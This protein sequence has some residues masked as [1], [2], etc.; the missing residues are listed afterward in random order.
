MHLVV[1]G[2][3]HAVLHLFWDSDRLLLGT[4]SPASSSSSSAS[5]SASPTAAGTPAR[6]RRTGQQLYRSLALRLPLLAISA[7]TRALASLFI[8]VPVYVL[9]LRAPSW[10]LTL[11]LFRPFY[12][13]P[14]SSLPPMATPFASTLDFV[15]RCMLAGFLFSVLLLVSNAAFSLFL[16]NEP[17]KDG[18]PLTSESKDPNGSLLN[19]LRSKKPNVKAFALWELAFIARDFS[20]RRVA[21]Y[22]DI[23]RKDGPAWSQ[24]CKVCLDV[25]A[26][27]EA[28]VDPQV[29]VVASAAAATGSE[30]DASLRRLTKSVRDHAGIMVAMPARKNT[31]QSEVEKMVTKVAIDPQASP[32]LSPM[33]HKALGGARRRLQEVQRDISGPENAGSS[34]QQLARHVLA[35]P[36]VGWP[37]RLTF[38][39]RITAAVL[40]GP[41]GEPSIY[42]NAISALRLLAVHSLQED[43]FG[44][45]QRDVAAIVRALT[46]ATAKLDAF[47]AAFPVH[48]TDVL[49]ERDCPEV[50]DIRA[51][52]KDGLADLLASFGQYSRDLRLTKTDVRLAEEAAS[53][54]RIQTDAPMSEEMQQ[55]R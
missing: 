40:G 23:E 7:F 50:D 52:L 30:E 3:L 48:W 26:T 16:V 9:F 25:V 36:V 29:V 45:V 35:L 34:V 31:F 18:R 54:G 32:R 11:A 53:S 14:K 5:P 15:P 2:T 24:I 44:N 12:S 39:N 33:A 6:G 28:R 51:A 42:V 27:L 38:R 43:K 46:A 21:I 49:A 55:V 13:L 17:L 19:G 22:T 4:A 37:F 8:S 47:R 10:R 1:V 20:D 41:Y